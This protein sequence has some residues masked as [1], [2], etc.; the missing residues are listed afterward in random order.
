MTDT[1][2]DISELLAEAAQGA[3]IRHAPVD[4]II[5]GGRRR[6]SRRRAAGAAA[7]LAVACTVGI[8]ASSSLGEGSGASPA[9]T[10]QRATPRPVT[11]V[12]ASGRHDGK[13]WSLSVDIWKRA[14][15]KKE[16]GRVWNAMEEVEYPDTQRAGGEGGPQLVDTG[17]FFANLKVG[18]RR[19]F[20]DDGA[21][22]A[23]GNRKVETS[24]GKLAP[25]SG[26]FVFGRTAPGVHAVTCTFDNGRKATPQLRTI[27]GTDSRFFALDAPAPKPTAGPPRCT[28]AD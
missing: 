13:P 16:A 18:E 23:T 9:A 26:W 22:N 3:R 17:W 19:S 24:W 8:A 2:T 15:D 7:A 25:S 21:L 14:A 5:V 20:V 11:E 1:G 12:I 6:R 28:A 10:E 27:A 4:A